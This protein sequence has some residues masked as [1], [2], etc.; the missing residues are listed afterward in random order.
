MKIRDQRVLEE[1]QERRGWKSGYHKGDGSQECQGQSI[2][3][4]CGAS[5]EVSSTDLSQS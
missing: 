1:F 5:G 2:G 3:K 4:D